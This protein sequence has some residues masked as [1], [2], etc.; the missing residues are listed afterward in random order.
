MVRACVPSTHFPPV[1]MSCEPIGQH[2]NQDMDRCGPPVLVRFPQ[3]HLYSFVGVWAQAC[4]RIFSPIKYLYF[5]IFS[6]NLFP[7]GFWGKKCTFY[8]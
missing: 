1:V 8:D 4:M 5:K 6:K 7:L 3:F 2:R